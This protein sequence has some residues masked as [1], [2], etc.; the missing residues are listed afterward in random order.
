M[1]IRQ[2][3]HGH[4]TDT[5][6]KSDGHQIKIVS[7]RAQGKHQTYTGLRLNEFCRGTLCIPYELCMY[8]KAMMYQISIGM[9]H[10]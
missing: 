4:Q 10:F 1:D 9:T 3:L 6:Q 5:G 7:R 2:T 8:I